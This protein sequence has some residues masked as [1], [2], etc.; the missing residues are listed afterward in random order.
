[1]GAKGRLDFGFASS[2]GGAVRP[3]AVTGL[4]GA[5]LTRAVMTPTPG[6]DSGTPGQS[7]R[8]D[9]PPRDGLRCYEAR[10]RPHPPTCA[11][12]LTAYMSSIRVGGV[13]G[14]ASELI[15]VTQILCKLLHI[16]EIAN[17]GAT[18]PCARGC[19]F[20]S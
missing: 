16:D 10:A 1:M 4:Q 6:R 17:A 11:V 3:R 5:A 19:E 2:C 13:F 18:R 8:R 20:E 14:H 12:Y 9:T 7:H 15:E